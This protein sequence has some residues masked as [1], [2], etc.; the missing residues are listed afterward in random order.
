MGRNNADFQIGGDDRPSSLPASAIYRHFEL[1]DFTPNALEDYK[2]RKP[3]QTRAGLMRRRQ[4]DAAKDWDYEEYNDIQ[5]QG[6]VHEPVE[7]SM[8][9]GTPRLENGHTRLALMLKYHPDKNIPIR[10][11]D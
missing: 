8:N 3:A 2:E 5:H 6:L 9:A 10:W 4:S 1:G 11:W 7:A